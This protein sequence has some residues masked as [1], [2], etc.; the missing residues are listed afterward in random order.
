MRAK[1]YK[2]G[3]SS[4]CLCPRSPASPRKK[5]PLLSSAEKSFPMCRKPLLST[6]RKRYIHTAKGNMPLVTCMLARFRN[7]HSPLPT[8]VPMLSLSRERE[9]EREASMP[10]SKALPY[11][12]L[13][14]L[15]RRFLLI[16]LLPPLSLLVGSLLSSL[17]AFACHPP[18]LLSAF[19]A[20]LL[21]QPA[22]AA[23]LCPSPFPRGGRRRSAPAVCPHLTAGKEPARHIA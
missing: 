15:R 9:R 2:T 16:L 18:F 1:W 19:P 11:A 14:R 3:F 23:D 17:A 5:A 4:G 13:C 10:S 12:A 21:V 20:F 22:S 8:G 6:L 7:E